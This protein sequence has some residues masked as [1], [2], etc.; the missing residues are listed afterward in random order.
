MWINVIT[1]RVKT[2]VAKSKRRIDIR[3]F[4]IGI[5]SVLLKC[6][7]NFTVKGVMVE[8]VYYNECKSLSWIEIPFSNVKFVQSC[9]YALC[10]SDTNCMGGKEWKGFIKYRISQNSR[11]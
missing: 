11:Y 3:D 10:N 9:K 8:T 2:V 1:L 6:R 4:A 7:D 5:Y